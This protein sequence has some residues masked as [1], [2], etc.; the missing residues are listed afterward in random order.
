MLLIAS[1]AKI[2]KH[3][4]NIVLKKLPLVLLTSGHEVY[5]LFFLS[6]PKTRIFQATLKNGYF[7]CLR[8]A[9]L[10]PVTWGQFVYF[11]SS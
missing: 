8:F 3:V 11:F 10:F 2:S 9:A 5:K 1:N 6:T 4:N 7:L